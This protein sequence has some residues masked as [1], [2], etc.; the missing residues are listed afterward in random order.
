MSGGQKAYIARVAVHQGS[1]AASVFADEKTKAQ[2][3]SQDQG[4]GL[5]LE[6]SGYF[7]G[8]VGGLGDE[9]F[10]TGLSPAIMAGVLV[11]RGDRDVYVSVGSADQTS[12]PPDIGTTDSGVVTAP[13]MCSLAQDLARKVLK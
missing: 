1:D 6:N 3:T 12:G 10:C 7:A 4:N 5:S 13:D 8:D 11:H 9:A 2:P